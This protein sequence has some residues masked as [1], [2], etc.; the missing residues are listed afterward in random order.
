M[1]CKH[2]V[3]ELFTDN[4]VMCNRE[5]IKELEEKLALA[6]S[7]VKHHQNS[8]TVAMKER[9]ELEEK[10]AVAIEALEKI[11]YSQ[12]DEESYT[13]AMHGIVGAGK[14]REALEKIKA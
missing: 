9:R 11:A 2:G 10:L 12:E 7:W 13:W 14:A 8:V 1:N 6:E 4:C 3:D 5:K